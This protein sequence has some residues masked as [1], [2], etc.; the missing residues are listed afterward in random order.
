[1][2]CG[3]QVPTGPRWIRS[4]DGPATALCGLAVLDV[5]N[6]LALKSAR[7]G[8]ETMLSVRPF[9]SVTVLGKKSTC[10]SLWMIEG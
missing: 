4:W 1:M 9:Q 7:D 6:S 2:R 5:R 10:G 8:A 3:I